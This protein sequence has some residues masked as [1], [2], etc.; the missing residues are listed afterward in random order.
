MRQHYS[1][2]MSMYV[3]NFSS[4]PPGPPTSIHV[5]ELTDST[6]TLSWK[7]GPD[8]HSPINAYTIQARTPFS[9]GWQAVATGNALNHNTSDQI[10]THFS[11]SPTVK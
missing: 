5:E 4:G 3:C 2:G 8:N 6:A 9:L 7:P 1:V 11:Q 10:S